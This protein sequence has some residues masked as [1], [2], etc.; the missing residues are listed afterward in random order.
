MRQH[1]CDRF[2][3][4][5]NGLWYKDGGGHPELQNPIEPPIDPIQAYWA[6]LDHET[7]ERCRKLSQFSELS[8]PEVAY[9]NR[10]P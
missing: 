1:T 8:A 2:A 4:P 6:I 5:W 10:R 3:C 7:R 9:T